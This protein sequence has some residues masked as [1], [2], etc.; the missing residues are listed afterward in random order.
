VVWLCGTSIFYAAALL[1]KETAALLPVLLLFTPA[2]GS[3]FTRRRLATAG[4]LIAIALGILVLRVHVGAA[5][6]TTSDPHYRLMT[7][8]RVWLRNLEV[9]IPRAIPSQIGL[10]VLVCL[11][12]AVLRRRQHAPIE[13]NTP[14]ILSLTLFA[15]VW[16]FVYMAPVLPIPARSELYLYFPTAG[17]C[18]LVGSVVDAALPTSQLGTSGLLALTIYTFLFGS[19]QVS[20]NRVLHEDLVFSSRLMKKVR[21]TLDGYTGHVSVVPADLRTA[22]FLS[23]SVWGYGDLMLKMATGRDDVSGD[24][25]YKGEVGSPGSLRL[26]CQ[27]SG[28]EVTLR[29]SAR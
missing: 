12:V 18:L 16:F 10:I 20:R 22:Q 6:P 17:L 14:G 5:M 27:Y 9:Y 29:P 4:V 15:L 24:V 25:A 21:V 8:P 3:L 11:P 23:D 1:S 26:E 28:R 7:P 13:W 19:Y 2:E